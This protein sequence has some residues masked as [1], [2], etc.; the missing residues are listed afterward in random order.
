MQNDK[1]IHISTIDSTNIGLAQ[2]NIKKVV[3]EGIG[4][5]EGTILWADFQSS[6]RGQRGNSWESEKSK[7]LTFSIIF[8]P[9]SIKANQQFLISQVVALGVAKFLSKYTDNISIKWPNDIYWKEK[10][11]CGILI[12]NQL[13]DNTII[14]SIAGIGININQTN[15]VSDAPNPVSLKLITRNDYSLA[16]LIEEVQLSILSYY[17]KLQD[18][19]IDFIRNDYKNNLFRKEGF[20]PYNDGMTNFYAEIQDILDSGILILK[21]KN[22]LERSFAFKEVKYILE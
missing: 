13:G 7:N 11:I 8:H 20:Y 2:L 6:G 12:E 16:T 10:K 21:D 22:G 3:K 1:I 17:K 4:L 9:S 18:G 14:H 5:L 19:E 15:F